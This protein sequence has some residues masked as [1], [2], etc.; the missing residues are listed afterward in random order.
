MLYRVWKY[1]LSSLL[2]LSHYK[3]TYNDGERQLILIVTKSL[4]N[5]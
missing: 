1:G 3:N 4:L 5:S 2:L